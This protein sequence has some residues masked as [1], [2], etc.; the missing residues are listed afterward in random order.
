MVQI[1]NGIVCAVVVVSSER[2]H[3]TPAFRPARIANIGM[4]ACPPPGD[5]ECSVSD[6]LGWWAT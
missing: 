2:R 4:T 6:T 3:R 1:V 5:Q